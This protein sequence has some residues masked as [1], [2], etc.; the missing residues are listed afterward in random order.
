MPDARLE[1][2]NISEP[3]EGV[4]IHGLYLEG[5]AF[6]KAGTYLKDSVG[7]ETF[8]P[9]PNIQIGAE[10][11][12]ADKNKGPGGAKKQVNTGEVWYECPVYRY[13]QRTDRYFITKLRI[14]AEQKQDQA[15]ARKQD[16]NQKET[17]A[18]INQWKLRGVALVCQKEWVNLLVIPSELVL[19]RTGSQ[20][21]GN[22]ALQ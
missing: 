2:K 4:Y 14:L 11:P 8:F 12:D 1:G 19:P 21:W 6:E 15:K 20:G 17:S 13:P 3:S 9:F 5:A 22:I 18:S 7:K 16:Q 10:C